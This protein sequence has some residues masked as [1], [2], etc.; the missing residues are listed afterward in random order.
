MAITNEHLNIDEVL[1]ELYHTREENEDLKLQNDF[2]QR[3]VNGLRL[4]L[5][6]VKSMGMF[7]FANEFCNETQLE[8]AGHQFAKSLLGGA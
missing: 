2:L 8:E 5:Q 1:D 6:R 3:Q 7:E 4:E